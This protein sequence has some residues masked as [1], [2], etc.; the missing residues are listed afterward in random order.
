MADIPEGDLEETRAALAPTLEATAA[1]LP[2]LSKP[3][4]PRFDTALN[5]R[6]IAAERRL[7][8]AWASR[9]ATCGAD[10]RP[11]IFNLYGI[12]I[13]TGDSDCLRLGEA[14]ASAAD[15]LEDE[16]PSTRLIAALTGTI[17][18]LDEPSGLE[19][20][21]FAERACHFA[22]RLETAARIS[23]GNERSEVIDRLFIDEAQEQLELM[24]DALTAVPPD[25]YVLMTESIGLAQHAETVELWGVMH[26][27]RSLADWVRQNAANLDAVAIYG[28]LSH[29][30][31][32]LGDLIASVTPA[33]K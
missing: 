20:D 13:E 23:P 5:E 30:L 8:Q 16:R 32:E 27:A 21:A 9:H 25:A 3:R 26:Q 29:K 7:V 19:H 18:C 28:Q 22:E 10:V 12:A 6:W 24:R 17:E 4:T 14:L 33:T 31:D 1:V 11:A 15:R 2:W